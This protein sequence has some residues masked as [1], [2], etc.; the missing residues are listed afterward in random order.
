MRVHNLACASS[1]FKNET[2][3][4]ANRD[5]TKPSSPSPVRADITN[6]GN[7]AIL[8]RLVNVRP[9][10]PDV[11]AQIVQNAF[12]YRKFLLNLQLTKPLLKS[13][14]QPFILMTAQ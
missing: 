7:Q 3:Q 8:R 5:L 9:I 11:A 6:H 1:A 4:G 2:V 10:A 13:G 12:L 14:P